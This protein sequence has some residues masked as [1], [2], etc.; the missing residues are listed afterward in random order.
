M[1]VRGQPVAVVPDRNTLF[2][3]GSEDEEGL[4]GLAIMV[5]QQLKEANRHI[6]AR[7]MV[8]TRDGWQR[9]DPL[10]S[11]QK[12]FALSARLLDAEYLLR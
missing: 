8:L 7:P 11:V 10:A 6:S 4:A 1:P 5:E 9:F 12:S 2:V 3:S